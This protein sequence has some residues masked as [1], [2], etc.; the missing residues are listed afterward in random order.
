MTISQAEWT[1]YAKQQGYGSEV[2]FWDAEYK[3]STQGAKTIRG[4]MVKYDTIIS[5]FITLI[6]SAFFTLSIL[7]GLEVW[8]TIW[9]GIILF[10]VTLFTIIGGFMFLMLCIMALMART[11]GGEDY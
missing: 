6:F 8:N 3:N 10:F 1:G 9:S 4:K 11:L 5:V 7:I 2:A